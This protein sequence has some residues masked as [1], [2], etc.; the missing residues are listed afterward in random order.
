MNTSDLKLSLAGL[1][2]PH[3]PTLC[4]Q[5]S[6]LV[7]LKDE[8]VGFSVCDMQNDLLIKMFFFQVAGYI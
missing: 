7:L 3:P 8:V 5:Q 2:Q 1:Y 6:L 4:K